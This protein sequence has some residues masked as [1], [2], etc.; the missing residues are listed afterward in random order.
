MSVRE[1]A[2]PL[3]VD[4]APFEEFALTRVRRVVDFRASQS[5]GRDV[6][7]LDPLALSQKNR[8]L[9]KVAPAELASCCQF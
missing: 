5:G 2:S 4:F 6:S 8:D 9:P 7:D 3:N 1:L